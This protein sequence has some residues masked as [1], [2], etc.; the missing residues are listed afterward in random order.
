VKVPAEDYIMKAGGTDD[1]RE[2]VPSDH[3]GK[4]PIDTA[5]QTFPASAPAIHTQHDGGELYGKKAA[6][7]ARGIM[8]GHLDQGVSFP[9]AIHHEGDGRQEIQ[10]LK[11]RE[12][13]K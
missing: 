3:G 12:L 7:G 6:D 2:H 4:H 9:D 10:H 11:V 5:Q 1:H 8:N 13:Q